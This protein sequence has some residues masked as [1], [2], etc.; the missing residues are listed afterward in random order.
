MAAEGY[1]Y[2]RAC[3]TYLFL[4]KTRRMA[5][6]GGKIRTTRSAWAHGLKHPERSLQFSLSAKSAFE[7]SATD[8][9][10][11]MATQR[12]FPPSGL[13]HTCGLR[14]N[15]GHAQSL[16]LINTGL[17][18]ASCAVLREITPLRSQGRAGQ[19]PICGGQA[20]LA[21]SS[22]QRGSS[23]SPRF[24]RFLDALGWTQGAAQANRRVQPLEIWDHEYC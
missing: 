9:Q 12:K 11:S 8:L 7:D 19:P 3:R 13:R 10:Y 2:A 20:P 14:R 16:Y 6:R 18:L 21:V 1:K 4:C 5:E 15:F 22:R 23:D 17:Y 24:Q